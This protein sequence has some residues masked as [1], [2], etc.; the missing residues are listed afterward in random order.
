LHRIFSKTPYTPA[1]AVNKQVLSL[2]DEI[3]DSW[4]LWAQ[5]MDV[6]GPYLGGERTYRKKIPA[7]LLWRKAAVR[8][9]DDITEEE[10]EQ[11]YDDYCGEVEYFDHHLG[12]LLDALKRRGELADTLVIVTADHGDEF[13][14]YGQ[15]GH[16]NLPYSKLTRV[17]SDSNIE[18]VSIDDLVRSV[19]IL[20]TALEYVDLEVEETMADRC[21]GRSLLPAACGESVAVEFALTEKRVRDED[22][23]RIG[24]R[25]RDWTFL[26]DGMTDE[27]ELYDLRDGSKE[28]TDV[29]AKHSA[30]VD[31]FETWLHERLESIEKTS[32]NV[33]I[34]DLST[35]AGVEERLKAL[36]YRD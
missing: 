19:D 12:Q 18:P 34:P 9:P 28:Q 26:Y 31:R 16:S 20:P 24:F 30:V 5:Y 6:H 7:E 8:S 32:E 36:G 13:Y 35:D 29:S 23:L 25:G 15:Y 22:A 10:H 14:E 27:T 2:I 3:D 17:P 4:F 11:L 21:E 33:S 1:P